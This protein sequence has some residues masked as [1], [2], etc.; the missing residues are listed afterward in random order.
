MEDLWCHRGAMEEYLRND[1][2][3]PVA[4]YAQDPAHKKAWISRMSKDGFEGPLNWF[5]AVVQGKHWEVEKDIPDERFPITVPVLF[6]GASRDS[7]LL[8]R[9]IYVA[10]KNGL[11]PELQVEEVDSGHWQTLEAPDKTGPIIA[12]WLRQKQSALAE[13]KT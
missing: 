4:K 8:T 2:K 7:S 12:A 9:N 13:G 3:G 1:K 10:Q 5:K 11:V 6:I